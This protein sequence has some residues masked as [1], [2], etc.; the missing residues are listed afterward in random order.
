MSIV[1]FDKQL[2]VDRISSQVKA[3]KSIKGAAELSRA[4]ADLRTTPAAFVIETANR[5]LPSRTGTEVV[6]Q[7]MAVRFGVV[8]AA[9]NLRDTR[10]DEGG[11]DL[12]VLRD[13]VMT[14]LLGWSVSNDFDPCEYAGGQLLQ[15]NDYTI[16]WQDDY[17]T[18]T[19]IRS[20]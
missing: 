10:G 9:Q 13:A 19:L 8:F 16:W 7:S 1:L 3:F 6:S 15:M 20:V 4:Q 18:S 11:A 14:A 12:N 2:V 5:P 17:L